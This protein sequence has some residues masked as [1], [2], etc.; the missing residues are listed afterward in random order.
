MTIVDGKYN[1]LLKKAIYER[2]QMSTPINGGMSGGPT[3]NSSGEV[4]GVNVSVLVGSDNIS[5]SVPGD[6]ASSMLKNY[7]KSGKALDEKDTDKTV[8]KQLKEIEIS[9]MSDLKG[10]K[11][12]T[13]ELGQWHYAT[14]PKSLKCWTTS[15]INK[16]KEYERNRQSCY[17]RD[18]AYIRSGHYSGSYELKHTTVKNLKFNGI[19]FYNYIEYLF[20]NI[21]I[22]ENIYLNYYK[23][24]DLSGYSCN[25]TVIVND[26]NIPFKLVYCINT[27]LRYEGLYR[28]KVRAA[29]LSGSDTAIIFTAKLDGFSAENI[30]NFIKEQLSSIG[31]KK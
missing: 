16:K 20:D 14:P 12:D 30:K 19:Q 5:F 23:S 9:L 21:S 18:A 4:I 7:K 24:D 17:L 26:N 6:K 2:I 25:E 15:K 13:T 29:S 10:N 31:R 22:A 27:F 28:A 11:K 1:G 8:E 3:V